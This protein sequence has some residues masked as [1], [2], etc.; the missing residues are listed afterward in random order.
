MCRSYTDDKIY[1]FTGKEPLTPLL[2]FWFLRK[3][4]WGSQVWWLI[5]NLTLGN[6]RQKDHPNFKAS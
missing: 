3:K 6:L 2:P 5:T 1:P 4:Q